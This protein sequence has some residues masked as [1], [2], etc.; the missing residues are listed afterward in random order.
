MKKLIVS[1]LT[2][3]VVVGTGV[4]VTVAYFT[5][6]ETST[7]NTFTTGT[8]DI[9]VDGQNPWEQSEQL[10]LED[11]KPSQHEYSEYVIH[12]VGSNPANIWK[13]VDIHEEKDN[14]PVSEPECL[15][16]GGRYEGPEE[17]IDNTPNPN[18]D[19]VIR[20]DMS[21]WV[22]E[23]DPED[24]D[25]EPKWW[26]VIYTDEMGVMLSTIDG[27]Q[28]MLGMVPAGWYM[29]VR[30]SYHMDSDAGN[31]YQGDGIVF[32]ITLMAE[33]LKGTVLMENK[34]FA[35]AENPTL[36]HGDGKLGAMTY[37]V[38]DATFDWEFAGTAPLANTEYAL[39][40]YPEL[41]SSPVGPGWPGPVTILG[42]E[43]TD[44]SGNVAMMGSED[45]GH[46]IRNMK[47]WLIPTSDLTG[48]MMNAWNG[49]DY[50]FEL[51]MMDYYDSL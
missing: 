42:T 21:V 41:W 44:A 39:I 43:T 38:K 26:Q 1:L 7:G 36:V 15:A 35:D 51:G 40:F 18:I 9:A 24:G 22:Y 48:N 14:L 28:N 16:E 29:K 31:E 37:T 30:Q 33:Q 47:V 17:C 2:L 3:A 34:D 49:N 19:E 5:D 12:N 27:Q 46:D 6:T 10:V 11:M 13:T 25:P 8:I 20:Y 32:D 50:L 4:G 23:T 45:F